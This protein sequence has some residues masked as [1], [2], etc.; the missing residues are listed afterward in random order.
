MHQQWPGSVAQTAAG[1]FQSG[2]DEC[3]CLC[4]EVLRFNLKS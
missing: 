3:D 2:L 1:F 4:D